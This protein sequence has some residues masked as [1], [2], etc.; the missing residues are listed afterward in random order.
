MTKVQVLGLRKKRAQTAVGL[1]VQDLTTEK[2]V[3]IINFE[4]HVPLSLNCFQIHK[5]YVL[6]SIQP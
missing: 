3:E 5:L 4:T 2:N 1:L 6:K